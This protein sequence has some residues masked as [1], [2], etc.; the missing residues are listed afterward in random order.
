MTLPHWLQEHSPTVAFIGLGAV[1]FAILLFVG[2]HGTFHGDEWYFIGIP[3]IGGFSDWMRPWNAHWSMVPLIVWKSVFAAVGFGSYLP[4]LAALLAVH[5]LA[6]TALWV[7]VRRACGAF[8]ALCGAACFLLLGSAYQN[9]VWAFQLGF[10]ISTAAGLWALV[11]LERGDRV[12][13]VGGALLLMVSLASS[14]MGVPFAVAASV[15]LLADRR[16]RRAIVWLVPVALVFAAWYVTWGHAGTLSEAAGTGTSNALTIASFVLLAPRLLIQ[17]VTGLGPIAAL[18]LY[19]A[20]VA[21]GV[22]AALRGVLSPRAVG[23]AAGLAALFATVTLGRGE[24]GLNYV[25]TTPRYVYEGAV[26]LILGVAALLG[27][28]AAQ[29]LPA[30]AVVAL[31][32]VAT[33]LAAMPAGAKQYIDQAGEVRGVIALTEAY[34][35]ER[36]N[37]PPPPTRFSTYVPAPAAMLDAMAKYGRLDRDV[38]HQGVVLPP[39]AEDLDRALWR[40]VGGVV[41]PSPAAAPSGPCLRVDAPITLLVT[42]HVTISGAGVWQVG[43]GRWAQPQGQDALTATLGAGWYSVRVPDLG[44]GAA[45]RLA[46][47]PP[48]ASAVNVCS[49]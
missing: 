13:R 26:F 19:L 37:Q 22:V 35:P 43:L 17:T 48:P 49:G 28:P 27:R 7:L 31:V 38:F 11:A 42:D 34:G 5:V 1:A 33:N 44:D 36:L 29:A 21:A 8:V 6:G 15:E 25:A 2:R 46:L 3:G 41:L 20:L 47:R 12:G 16:R 30:I 40:V 4:Y 18:L 23:A 14:G 39:T 45:Y 32:I 9:L 24:L 10:V